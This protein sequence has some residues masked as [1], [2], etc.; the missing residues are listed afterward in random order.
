MRQ[1]SEI[2]APVP[3]VGAQL[4]LGQADG[5][6][7]VVQPLVLERRQVQPAADAVRPWP[8]ISSEPAWA[9]SVQILV[10][11]AFELLDGLAAGQVQC[12]NASGE[13]EELAAVDQ[14]RA[15]RAHVDLSGAAVEQPL[16]GVLELGAAHDGVLAE[17]QPL[18]VD[19]LAES[20]SASSGPPGRAS[21]VLGHEAARPGRRV[22]DERPAVGNSRFVGIPDGM[23]DAR[24]GNAGHEV[25]LDVVAARQGG[26]AAVADVLH[27]DALVLGGRIAV[28]DPQERADLHRLPG[29]RAAAHRL[30]RSEDDLAGPEI[31]CRLVVQVGEGAG[32]GA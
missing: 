25:D 3:A 27:I 30:R 14:R 13:I 21:L 18:A 8:G 9:Y 15:G 23:A 20:G 22:L 11:L 6:H 29:R 5:R 10:V 1:V 31:T 24:I 32:F 19:Q 12:R 7:Q 16:D 4:L 28:V 26:A 17:Q 2:T